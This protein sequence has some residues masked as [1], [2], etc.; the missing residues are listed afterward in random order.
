MKIA[1]ESQQQDEVEFPDTI[2]YLRKL[3]S[4]RIN[5]DELHV[6][7]TQSILV[8]LPVS[9]SK[10][11]FHLG[12]SHFFDLNAFP[13]FGSVHYQC[14]VHVVVW[15]LNGGSITI[16]ENMHRQRRL[17]IEQRLAH[18]PGRTCLVSILGEHDNNDVPDV[19]SIF[20]FQ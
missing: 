16:T 13:D 10:L 3:Q 5:S 8:H 12:S 7:L 15:P 1:I 4:L 14:F 9:L 19:N 18:T 11:E 6:R 2:R 20:A 17:L